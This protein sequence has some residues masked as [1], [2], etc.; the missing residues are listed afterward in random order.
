MRGHGALVW[1]DSETMQPKAL[2]QPYGLR[3]CERQAGDEV[4]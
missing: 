2:L 1:G 4:A 3:P